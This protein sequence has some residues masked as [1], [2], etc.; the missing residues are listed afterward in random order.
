MG[1][2]VAENNALAMPIVYG[3][4]ALTAYSNAPDINDEI[5][6]GLP[7]A[8]LNPTVDGTITL[9]EIT[10]ELIDGGIPTEIIIGAI[11][12]K[13]KID[14][15][16]AKKVVDNMSVY[17][18]KRLDDKLQYVGITNDV[19]RR[20]AEHYRTKGIEIEP[21]LDNLSKSDARALEQT[22]IELSGLEKNGGTLINKINSISK[23]NPDYAKQL[24]RGQELLEIVK[25]KGG[26]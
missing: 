4:M 10:Q 22:L 18:S 13:F 24:Q 2:S 19:A 14:E 26:L 23:T 3:L 21:I 20:Q 17:V 5:K 9:Y 16:T 8:L 25:T 1:E 15:T 6:D 7:L 12:H 11:A